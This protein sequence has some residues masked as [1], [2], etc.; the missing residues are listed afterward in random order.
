MPLC[1][2]LE[3]NRCDP[4]RGA[5]FVSQFANAEM[6]RNAR[7][8][9]FFPDLSRTSAPQPRRSKRSRSHHGTGSAFH[10][11]DAGQRRRSRVCD[12][13]SLNGA[14]RLPYSHRHIPALF[15][16]ANALLEALRLHADASFDLLPR[17]I[18]NSWDTRRPQSRAPRVPWL[19]PVGARPRAIVVRI[20]RGSGIP[21]YD[22]RDLALTPGTFAQDLSPSSGLASPPQSTDR[23]RRWEACRPHC[24]P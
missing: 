5:T 22:D 15:S 21:E 24:P 18:R 10:A 23:A 1:R 9:A 12:L 7:T 6:K 17:R 2:V 13:A 14:A 11:D 20:D 16:P 4:I 3:S 19:H 8:F